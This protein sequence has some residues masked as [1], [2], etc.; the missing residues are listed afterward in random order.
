MSDNADKF[1]L[2]NGKI[3]ALQRDLFKGSAF[4]V[5]KAQIVCFDE[6]HRQIPPFRFD[7]Q[8][9]KLAVVRGK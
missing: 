1:S 5:H 6:C 2:V 9:S 7:Y 8:Q 3:R 4:A